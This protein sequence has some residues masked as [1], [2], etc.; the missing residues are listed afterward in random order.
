MNFLEGRDCEKC[1]DDEIEE[2]ERLLESELK[3]QMEQMGGGMGMMPPPGGA[4]MGMPPPPGGM[5]MEGEM[6]GP[7][8]MEAG[9]QESDENTPPTANES[10]LHTLEGMKTRLLSE[11]KVDGWKTQALDRILDRLNGKEDNFTEV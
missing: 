1:E 3:K 6:A 7:S 9:G 10:L 2:F 5:P 4:P 8:P 11:G